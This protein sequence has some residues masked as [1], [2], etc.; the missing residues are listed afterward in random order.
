MIEAQ[1]TLLLRLSS[2]RRSSSAE[3]TDELQLVGKLAHCKASI[4]CTAVPGH[5]YHLLVVLTAVHDG[6]L[7]KARRAW[8]YQHCLDV[9]I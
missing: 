6:A 8:Y 5:L 2:A 7:A 4:H 3:V 1:L 9:I